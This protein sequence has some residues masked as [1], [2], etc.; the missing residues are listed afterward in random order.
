MVADIKD[1]VLGEFPPVGQMA[2]FVGY[3]PNPPADYLE[4]GVAAPPTEVQYE[5]IVFKDGSVALRWRTEYRST[6]VW[7]SFDD[8]FHVHGHPE[9]GTVIKWRPVTEL[10]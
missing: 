3:R 1:L 4:K 10:G 8:F 9:Y 7:A 5:G 6:S 2:V